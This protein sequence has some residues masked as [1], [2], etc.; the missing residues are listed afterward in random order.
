MLSG[1]VL[2]IAGCGDEAKELDS[3]EIHSSSLPSAALDKYCF[4]ASD[5]GWNQFYLLGYYSD[6]SI[7]NLS[8]DDNTA[9]SREDSSGDYSTLS[10]AIPGLLTFPAE[11]TIILQGVYTLQTSSGSSGGTDDNTLSDAVIIEVKS[12]SCN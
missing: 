6:D 9:W 2:F 1:I 4:D 12:T 7:E 8:A 5:D 3:V 11:G 10:T